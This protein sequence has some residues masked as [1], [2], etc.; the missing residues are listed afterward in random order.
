MNDFGDVLRQHLDDEIDTLGAEN[1][2]KIFKTVEEAKHI[3]EEAVKWAV[4]H[5]SLTTTIPFV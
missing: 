2:S 5:A 4:K 1:L 3:M